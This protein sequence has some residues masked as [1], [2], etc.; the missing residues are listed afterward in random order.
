[1][2]GKQLQYPSNKKGG[3][4]AR[5]DSSG[6]HKNSC[7]SQ[8]QAPLIQPLASHHTDYAFLASSVIFSSKMEIH[9]LYLIKH[10]HNSIK[11]HGKIL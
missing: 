9:Q 5:L 4:R 2:P 11:F 7:P 1:M 3:P 8:N 6:E 10:D